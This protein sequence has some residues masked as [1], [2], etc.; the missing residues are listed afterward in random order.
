MKKVLASLLVE[1]PLVTPRRRVDWTFA[2]C[3]AGLAIGLA[4]LFVVLAVR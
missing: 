1:T 3:A 2:L 4:V